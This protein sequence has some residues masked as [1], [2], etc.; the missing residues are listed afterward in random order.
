[1]GCI[2]QPG[3]V[4]TGAAVVVGARGQLASRKCE[5][6]AYMRC[7]LWISFYE[8]SC[9]SHDV[10]SK[11]ASRTRFSTWD[12]LN[13]LAPLLLG[14]P[15]SS[16][17]WGNWHNNKIVNFEL[18]CGGICV[19]LFIILSRGGGFMCQMLAAHKAVAKCTAPLK[20]SAYFRSVVCLG[21]TFM[22]VDDRAN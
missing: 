15:W 9:S 19:F 7:Y 12:I 17:L 8:Q 10:G 18:T 6:W 4:V 14:R 3:A 13:N 21:G 22:K 1:M 16:E 20:L 5:F 11:N 2:K